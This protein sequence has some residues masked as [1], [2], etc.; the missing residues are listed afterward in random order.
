[1]QRCD[2]MAQDEAH[3]VSWEAVLE[4][5][6]R[7]KNTTETRFPE[8]LEPLSGRWGD[9]C[10]GTR[11]AVSCSRGKN[12]SH[13][14]R[15]QNG[16]DKPPPSTCNWSV[17]ADESGFRQEPDAAAASEALHISDERLSLA[18]VWITWRQFLTLLR[19]KNCNKWVLLMHVFRS[20]VWLKETS[21]IPPPPPS[22]PRRKRVDGGERRRSHFDR[23]CLAVLSSVFVSFTERQTNIVNSGLDWGSRTLKQVYAKFTS[24]GKECWGPQLASHTPTLDEEGERRVIQPVLNYLVSSEVTSGL[25]RGEK[26]ELWAGA[27]QVWGHGVG[28]VSAVRV[29]EEG[30]TSTFPMIQ[31]V[32]FLSSLWWTDQKAKTV[33]SILASKI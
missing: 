2:L 10:H 27:I 17:V 3:D 32:H 21:V 9:G 14:W 18:S 24:Q 16:G 13:V 8:G 4:C 20:V 22:L 30:E 29:P 5:W 7:R 15:D 26:D 6:K 12:C 31:L 28:P 1:M 33:S 19:F 11:L 23:L 25:C